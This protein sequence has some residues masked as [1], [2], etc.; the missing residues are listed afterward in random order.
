MKD[1]DALLTA[2]KQ[3]IMQVCNWCHYLFRNLLMDLPPM[4]LSSWMA[5]EDGQKKEVKRSFWSPRGPKR[6]GGQSKP[7]LNWALSI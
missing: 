3:E 4:S 7:P 1:V 5:T 6:L 2:K